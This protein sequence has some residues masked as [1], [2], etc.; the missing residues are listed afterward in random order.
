MQTDKNSVI[1]IAEAGVNH[2]GNLDMARRMVLEA[3]AA[4]ADYVKFQ[5]AVPELVISVFAPKAEYQKETTGNAESQLDMCRAIH[6]PL[7]DYAELKA[8][9]DEVGIGFMSTPFDLVSIDCLAPLGM[10]YWKIPSGEITNL[11]YLRKIGAQGGRVIMSTGMATVPEVEAALDVLASAGTPRTSVILLHC[12]TQYPAP[13]ESVNLRAMDALAAL[14]CA[15]VGYSDHTVGTDVAVAA[16]GRG[17]CVIE[18]HFTLD[19]TLP[20]PDH[21]ASLEPAELKE[22]V[23]AVRRAE[24]ALGDGCKQAAEAERPNIAIARKSIV[25]ARPISAG[26][27]LTEENITVKR[28]GNGISPML[29]DSV[30]GTRAVRDFEYDELISLQ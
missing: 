22:L 29:W 11:P 8:L 14:G 12:T 25:A 21:R 15:G 3:K 26:E 18:K 4:G 9:C 24:T 1:I 30:I 16:V 19:K 23:D 27:V 17:A 5:T 6:L 7:S 20:G 13:L 2:N 10:D 28:P